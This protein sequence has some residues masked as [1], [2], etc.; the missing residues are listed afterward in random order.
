MFRVCGD[1]FKAIQ[2][3]LVSVM[4]DIENGMSDKDFIGYCSSHC[5]SERALFV[6]RDVNRMLKLAGYPNGFVS[7][8]PDGEWFS[9]H[10]PMEELVRHAERRLVQHS[11]ALV[12]DQHVE[13]PASQRGG[14]VLPFRKKSAGPSM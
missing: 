2:K 10:E 1:T 12:I 3:T 4:S 5:K 13:G 7:R 6:G 11:S 14:V 9:L 8:V